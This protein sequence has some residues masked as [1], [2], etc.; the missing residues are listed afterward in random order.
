MKNE[1]AI[2]PLRQYEVHTYQW[3]GLDNQ[4]NVETFTADD[5]EVVDNMRVRFMRTGNLIREY[6]NLPTKVIV[7]PA[8]D[9]QVPE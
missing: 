7:T 5:Y 3:N 9:E 1:V 2:K 6:F 4:A 8:A